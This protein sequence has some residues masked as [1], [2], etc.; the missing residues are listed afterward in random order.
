[1]RAWHEH[2]KMFSPLARRALTTETHGQNSWVNY[3]EGHESLPLKERPFAEQKAIL[4]PETHEPL[5]LAR[6]QAPKGGGISD[7]QYQPGGRFLAAPFARIRQ[8]VP[9]LRQLRPLQLPLLL[10]RQLPL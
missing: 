4:L 2:A 3:S 10:L 6:V 7:N 1:M 5:R 9:L 8:V